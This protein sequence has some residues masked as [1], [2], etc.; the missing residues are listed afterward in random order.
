M[1]LKPQDKRLIAAASGG[2]L[3]FSLSCWLVLRLHALIPIL[4]V[5]F[6]LL[7]ALSIEM[8]RRVQRHLDSNTELYW[9]VQSLFELHSLVKADH[10]LPRMRGFAISPDF[11]ALLSATI[12]RVKPNLIVECG[13]G[14]STVVSAYVLRDIGGGRIL[15]LEHEEKY[16]DA[17]RRELDRHGLTE[18][19]EVIHA[20]LKTQ[21]INGEFLTWYDLSNVPADLAIDLLTVDGPPTSSSGICARY[22]AGPALLPRLTEKGVV[23]LD[24]TELKPNIKEAAKRWCEQFPW[25]RY[26]EIACEKGAVILDRDC[27]K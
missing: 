18:F 2:F 1:F 23:L 19:A 10:P 8:Y 13:C 16:A 17:C 7:A 25:L 11:A 14:T 5:M 21:E 6:T 22:P 26:D 24:D 4:W 20:P 9:Q 27:P 15:S 12:R 3:V